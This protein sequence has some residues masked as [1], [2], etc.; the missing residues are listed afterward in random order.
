MGN[1]VGFT[2][3]SFSS[4]K[5]QNDTVGLLKAV[6]GAGGILGAGADMTADILAELLAWYEMWVNPEKIDMQYQFVQSVK[7]TAGAIA[8][9]HYR[10]QSINMSVSG[11]TGWIL[12]PTANTN[13]QFENYA[14]A[15]LKQGKVKKSI[16]TSAKGFIRQVGLPGQ[17]PG[18]HDVPEL[19]QSQGKPL[20]AARIKDRSDNSAR[21][22]LERLR[23]IADEPMYYVDLFGVEHY[24]TKYIKI[25]TKQYPKGVICEGYYTGFN[26]PEGKDD[27]QTIDYNFSFV[28][29]NLK[30][31]SEA[32][33]ILGKYAGARQGTGSAVRSVSGFF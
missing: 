8:T 25:Y 11:K 18:V 24:N 16:Q 4:K 22:F 1:I 21:Q 5:T 9:F 15:L 26:I 12:N 3:F 17:L 20:G 14:S 30:P 31:I 6:G 10:R 23:G 29:E 27:K 19:A 28:V 32:Q 33:K 13:G 2:P 7:Q